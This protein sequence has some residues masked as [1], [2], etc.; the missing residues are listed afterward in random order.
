MRDTVLRPS[1]HAHRTKTPVPT[2]TDCASVSASRALNESPAELTQS[3][4]GCTLLVYRSPK[5]TARAVTLCFGGEGDVE[6][7]DGVDGSEGFV[8]SE[9]ASVE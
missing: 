7:D 8:L 2:S 6:I 3:S 4:R 5:S 1:S 9:Q